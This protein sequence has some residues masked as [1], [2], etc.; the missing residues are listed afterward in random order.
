MNR[1][2]L[3]GLLSLCAAFA[4]AQ[5][6]IPANTN[7]NRL[8]VAVENG[9]PWSDAESLTVRISRRPRGV[10]FRQEEQR[11]GRL[12]RGRS[13]E[14][15][16]TFDVDRTAPV[17]RPDTLELQIEGGGNILWHRTSPW[18]FTGPAAFRLEQ[19][20][21]NPFNPSCVVRYE[22]PQSVR[23]VLTIYDL[24]GRRVAVADEGIREAGYHEVAV[25]AG[26]L[27]S[28]VYFYR[29]E[30]GTFMATRKMVIVR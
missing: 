20:F 9:S 18:T 25:A 22:L 19:N 28:G 5:T 4:A 29:L 27:P 2:S 11:I 23:A 15:L 8:V 14:V 10:I 6:S 24:L 3:I 26:D 12:E 21:P 1:L 17:N 16:F 7:G 30:A 13:T